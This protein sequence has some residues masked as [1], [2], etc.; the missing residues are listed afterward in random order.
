MQNRTEHGSISD[1]L[2]AWIIRY[3]EQ[4]VAGDRKPAVA[5]KIAT[6]LDRFRSFYQ[7]RNGN[8]TLSACLKRDVEAWRDHLREQCGLSVATVN[9]HLASLSGFMTWVHAQSPSL[10]VMG[11]P[12]RG[13]GELPSPPLEPRALSEAQV[14]SLKR[15]CDRL[16]RL[17]QSQ[18]QTEQGE[19]RPRAYTR[20]WR[21]RAIILVLLSTGLRREELVNLDLVQVEPSDPAELRN[22]RRARIRRVRG[23]VK[24]EREVWL[25]QDGRTALADYLEQERAGDAGEETTALFLSEPSRAARLPDGRMS[26][27]AINRILERIGRLHDGE[28][29][30]PARRI[31]PLR[32]HDLRHTFAFLLAKVTGADS[33]E[34]E[35]RL[36]HRS[37]RYI[38]R[39]T[40]PPADVAA[41]YVEGF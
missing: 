20:P 13:I 4:V 3:G 16:P 38:Q 12:T 40:N 35:R 29:S 14:R 18:R 31:S 39:Y 19:A 33:Y 17:C 24:S 6:H 25:S 23:K 37:Q 15:F 34:L 36:G 9:A 21:D 1:D 41:G 32:P 11:K 7:D 10:F 28:Q 30:D 22:A 27:R 5:R 2:A 8:D 26:T